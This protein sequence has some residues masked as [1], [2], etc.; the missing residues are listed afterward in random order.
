MDGQRLGITT[1]QCGG[2]DTPGIDAV[3]STGSPKELAQVLTN[4]LPQDLASSLPLFTAADHKFV[5]VWRAAVHRL[6]GDYSSRTVPA[7]KCKHRFSK[8]IFRKH[9]TMSVIY[10]KGERSFKTST[11]VSCKEL[12]G[13]RCVSE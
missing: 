9:K 3:S 7:I 11:T 2:W 8:L 10:Y 5:Q 1:V 12:R 4:T 13:V 6:C